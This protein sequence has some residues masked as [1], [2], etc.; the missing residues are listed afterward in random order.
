[1]AALLK[2]KNG[3]EIIGEIVKKTG[4]NITIQNPFIINY[5]FVAGQPVPSISVSRYMPFSADHIHIFYAEDVLHNVAPSATFEAYYN[6]ALEY[7]VDIVDRSIDEELVDAASRTKGA[8]HELVDVYKAILE[9]TS[10]DGPL[11]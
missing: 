1:M 11:N 3:T 9:R 7:C 5:R 8:K 6:N 4:T 2:L 10:F